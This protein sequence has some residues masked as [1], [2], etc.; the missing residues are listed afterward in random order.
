MQ[1][2]ISKSLAPQKTYQWFCKEIAEDRR[3][4]SDKDIQIYNGGKRSPCIPGLS[5]THLF[6]NDGAAASGK[7][8]CNTEYNVDGRVND[9]NG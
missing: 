3:Y 7:H 4:G 8:D 9:I 2:L 5:F 6:G 1:S